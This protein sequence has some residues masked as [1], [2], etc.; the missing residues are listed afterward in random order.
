MSD[1]G[2]CV[3]LESLA[4]ACEKHKK[5]DEAR[6]QAE[7]KAR[8]R[9]LNKERD[10]KI[11]AD[12][13]LRRRDEQYRQSMSPGAIREQWD[14]EMTA[15]SQVS[16]KRKE[17]K[18]QAVLTRTIPAPPTRPSSCPHG[19]PLRYHCKPCKREWKEEMEAF[20]ETKDAVLQ[21]I[22]EHE[23]WLAAQPKPVKRARPA[24]LQD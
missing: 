5:D 8:Y 14:L 6:R 15:L 11:R 19:H 9:Q 2:A 3:E 18:S 20:F 13:V 4:Q 21:A 10:R 1:P 17:T 7:L 22:R 24:K 12:Y 16:E 23:Q